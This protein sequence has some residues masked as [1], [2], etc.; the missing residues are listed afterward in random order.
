MAHQG[1]H[2]VPVGDIEVLREEDEFV[3]ANVPQRLLPLLIPA[4][5][6]DRQLPSVGRPE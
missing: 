5:C 2:F 1:G 6:D 4:I 3:V